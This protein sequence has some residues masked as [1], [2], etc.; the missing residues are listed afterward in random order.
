MTQ[1][2]SV[3][4]T[5]LGISIIVLITIVTCTI[6]I[7]INLN[8]LLTNALHN[9]FN[10]NLISNVYELK[11]EDLEANILTG[12]VRVLNVK[13]YP[14]DN[15]VHTYPYINSSLRLE[16]R[17]MI[18]K[19]VDLILLLRSNKLYLEKIE[20]V[21]PGIDFT[22]AD[23][24]PIF[25]P[26][27][28]KEAAQQEKTDKKSIESYSLKEFSMKDASF[29]VINLAKVRE[30]NI[31]RI[32]LTVKDILIDQQPGR[33]K[34]SYAHFDFSIG[35]LT[36]RL[37]NKELRYINFKDF[38]VNIDSL[39]LE[40]TQDTIL[41]HFADVKTGIDNLDI[42]TADST[43]HITMESFNV[44]YD[45][46]SVE[47]CNLS[48]KPNISDAA[49]QKK[50]PYRK[51][52]FAGT[53]GNIQISGVNFD[54]LIYKRK[55]V[56]DEILL[57]DVSASIYKDLTKPF[58]PDHRPEYLGQQIKAIAWPVIIHQIK[59]THVNLVNTEVKPDGGIG[60]ANIR[61]ASLTIEHITNLP[62][63][64][65]LTV[66]ADAYVENKAHAY[67]RL[68]FDYNKPQFSIDGKVEKFDLT[69]LNALTN[70]YAPVRIKE[71]IADG[72]TFSGMVFKTGSTGTMKF[73]YH[74]LVIDMELE[75]KA[76]W[77]SLVL[78]LV[79][80]TYISSSN[81]SSANLPERV[82]H[83]EV[84]RDMRKGY[85]SMTI[86]SIL[87]GVKETFIMSK[88]NKK[89]YREAKE[90]FKEKAKEEKKI[91]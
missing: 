47:L 86:K 22:I 38:K 2:R 27:K 21:E 79:A 42:Q 43:Y 59:A 26:F 14:R 35:E 55:I 1:K 71:G 36:G 46:K 62:T 52:N 80:N 24:N 44:R 78:G 32:N 40:E 49:L 70:S 48:F 11:F 67:L 17:K 77:K 85:L 65:N 68:G 74:D 18:L 31:Q 75:D 41:Y 28:E 60:K 8:R 63:V 53:I 61:R 57:D 88:E 4:R 84:E 54:S 19:N 73:L 29:H 9:G 51:E 15:P 83:F 37:E 89:A 20:L 3:K 56:I 69:D 30:F 87:D 81:P 12:S 66:S 16:A 39:Y 6:F 91:N 90:N 64:E 76:E 10:D 33:D 13:M 25:F 34:I 72:I 5:I 45:K 50:Y 82:V 58:P 7:Y 23:V